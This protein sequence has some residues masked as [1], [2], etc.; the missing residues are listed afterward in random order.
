[1][2]ESAKYDFMKAIFALL[3]GPI[4]MCKTASWERRQQVLRRRVVILERNKAQGLQS[5]DAPKKKRGGGGG[6]RIN[7]LEEK[8]SNCR[9]RGQRRLFYIR[10][11]KKRAVKVRMFTLETL[12]AAKKLSR[13]LMTHTLSDR[14][15]KPYTTGKGSPMSIETKQQT[16]GGNDKNRM[17]SRLGGEHRSISSDEIGG[18][19][20]WGVKRNL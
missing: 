12:D 13:T 6:E 1:M 10:V 5:T 17:L 18:H 15:V 11:Q 8:G 9:K 4:R 2:G 19:E 3:G 16:K 14:G 20:L 7:P